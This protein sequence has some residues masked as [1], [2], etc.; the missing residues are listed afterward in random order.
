MIFI[1]MFFL[2]SRNIPLV[3]LGR[4]LL[5]FV[6]SGSMYQ[7]CAAF[8][9]ASGVVFSGLLRASAALAVVKVVVLDA[10]RTRSIQD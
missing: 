5:S 7:T 1:L 8:F 2:S 9:W 6:L 3:S 10:P 4:L